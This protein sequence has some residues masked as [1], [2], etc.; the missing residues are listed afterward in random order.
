M[1]WKNY[2]A[3]VLALAVS[4][5][6]AAASGKHAFTVEDWAKLHQ[7]LA[8]AV[9]PDARTILYRVDHGTEKGPEQQEWHLIS[10]DGS[11]DR[12]LKLPEHFT[13][14]GFTKDGDSLYGLF[15]VSKRGQLA[16]ISLSSPDAKLQVLTSIPSGVNH[17]AL[18]P[19]G[20]RF[21]LLANPAPVDPLEEVH[22][23][24]E[25]APTSVYV[26]GADGKNG[27]WW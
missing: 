27:A 7:A 12:A 16:L 24:V 10:S 8:I 25:D 13:P 11:N 21:A 14:K 3:C 18:S 15:E 23:V 5:L 4:S 22:T 20:A 17:A 6:P 9:A 26:I 19:D 1:N 2:S